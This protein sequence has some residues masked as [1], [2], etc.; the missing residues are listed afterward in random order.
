MKA[1]RQARHVGKNLGRHLEAFGPAPLPTVI[2]ISSRS[3]VRRR[4]EC[5]VPC[6]YI[7]SLLASDAPKAP[8]TT[9]LIPYLR[10]VER[11]II[12]RIGLELPSNL[13]VSDKALRDAP[14]V[15]LRF[16]T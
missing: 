14:H 15:S 1:G 7:D 11:F 10:Q 5:I 12:L 4:V 3:N 9:S 8:V 6:R 13:R 2:T 16:F